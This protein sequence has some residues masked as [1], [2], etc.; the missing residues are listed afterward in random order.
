MKKSVIA[1]SV[2]TGMI[3]FTVSIGVSKP[4][5]VNK[6]PDNGKN[7]GCATCHVNP[8]GG[9]SRN[10]FGTDYEKIGLKGGD[11]YTPE[12]GEL[13]S[14]KDGATNDQEFEA[15]TNPG[16]PKSKP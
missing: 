11:K 13:D 9:G 4:F 7:F 1:F 12:L 14:D 8:M 2:I 5:R 6:M 15:G 10:F 16:D 3:L